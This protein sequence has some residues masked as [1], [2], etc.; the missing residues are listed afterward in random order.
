MTDPTTAAPLA[1]TPEPVLPPPVAGAA[2]S[3]STSA[4]GIGAIVAALMFALLDKY[5]IH[6]D[7]GTEALVGGLMAALAG[8]LPKSGRK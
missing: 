4:S 8:Y 7:A 1:P 2:P 5:G 3:T 6:L